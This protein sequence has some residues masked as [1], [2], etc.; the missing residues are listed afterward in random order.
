M[1]I[2]S[3]IPS[4]VFVLLSAF[5]AGFFAI[6]VPKRNRASEASNNFRNK[7]LDLFKDVYPTPAEKQPDNLKE[8]IKANYPSLNSEV[9]KFRPF[10]PW[11]KRKNFDR[12][13]NE[14]RGFDKDDWFGRNTD[15]FKYGEYSIDGVPNKG[16]EQFHAN[17]TTLVSYAKKI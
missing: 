11:Y 1:S 10:V 4:G 16:Y 17:L 3:Q 12:D 5:I 9:H 8:V 14:F 13:W 7:V 6:I 2:F 15:F